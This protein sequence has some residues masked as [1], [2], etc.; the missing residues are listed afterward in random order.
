MLKILERESGLRAK[1]MLEDIWKSDEWE[2][3]QERRLQPRQIPP[4]IIATS[5]SQQMPLQQSL[6]TPASNRQ[7]YKRSE[8]WD[9]SKGLESFILGN[10]VDLLNTLHPSP[11]ASTRIAMKLREWLESHVST[12]LWIHGLPVSHYP[13]ELSALAG[14]LINAASASKTPVLFHFCEPVKSSDILAGLTEEQCGAISLALSLIRQLILLLEP[15]FDTSIDLEQSRFLSLEKPFYN[16]KDVLVLLESLFDLSPELL[17]C[18][19]DGLDYLD[20]GLGQSM[21]TDILAL[22]KRRELSSA[23]KGFVLKT[24]FTSAGVSMTLDN[25]LG[26]DEVVID[27]EPQHRGSGKPGPGQKLIFGEDM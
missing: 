26:L 10:S 12:T 1:Y 9:N 20:Y 8:V 7:H 24:L 13:N 18:V 15:E 4:S 6:E 16:W 27:E 19:I 17:L 2:R 14:S 3:S 23:T 21:C 11:F 22:L 5:E 25:K